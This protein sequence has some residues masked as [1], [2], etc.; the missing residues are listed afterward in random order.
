M[1]DFCLKEDFENYTEEC[2]ELTE[3]QIEERELYLSGK[4]SARNIN[5]ISKERSKEISKSSLE[6]L[7][8]KEK[9]N[10]I[11]L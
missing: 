5:N 3:F 6:S 1:N 10:S 11:E 2:C 8:D 4:K 7:L 9:L